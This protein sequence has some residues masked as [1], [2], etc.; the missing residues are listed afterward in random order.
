MIKKLLLKLI[1][2][3]IRKYFPKSINSTRSGNAV[4]YYS[5]IFSDPK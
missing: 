1:I 3:A 4:I 5:F 2:W